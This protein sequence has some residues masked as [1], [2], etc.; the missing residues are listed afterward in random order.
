M[1]A[2]SG[3]SSALTR[4]ANSKRSVARNEVESEPGQNETLLDAM[5]ATK[6]QKMLPR[7]PWVSP[8]VLPRA[9][10]GLNK[11]LAPDDRHG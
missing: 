9:G 10:L 3:S 7:T 5:S 1:P 11:R 2:Q 4:W 6:A 8:N